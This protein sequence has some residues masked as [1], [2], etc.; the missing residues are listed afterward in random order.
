MRKRTKPQIG[1]F[2]LV[3]NLHLNLLNFLAMSNTSKPNEASHKDSSKTGDP[4]PPIKPGETTSN[5][6][7]AGNTD[8]VNNDQ[9]PKVDRGDP[10]VNPAVA[11][12]GAANA[13]FADYPHQE[14]GAPK[15]EA[16]ADQSDKMSEAEW[17]ALPDQSAKK[18]GH[19]R[20]NRPSKVETF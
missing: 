12:P 1:A 18:L 13:Q 6:P 16:K 8:G 4:T 15:K 5:A 3:L 7:K 14:G 19:S 11:A 9:K 10:S 17:D 20:E 2:S